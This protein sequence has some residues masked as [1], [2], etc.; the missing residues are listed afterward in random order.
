MR[1]VLLGP[2]GAGKG[3]QARRL[4]ETY[5]LAHIASGDIFLRNI[6]EE[7]ELGKL[8]KPHYE[9][10]RLVPDELTLGMI[11]AAIRAAEDGFVLDGFPRNMVQA[12]IL[13]KE[14]ESA[15]RP[16]QAALAFALDGE[17]AVKRI[18]GRRTCENDEKH[19]FNVYFSPPRDRNRCD[20]C[21][22]ALLQRPDQTEEA[23]RR[24]FEVYREQTAPLLAFYSER[25]LLREVDASGSEDEVAERV[26]GALADLAEERA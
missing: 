6:R 21:G 23:V 22:G 10:G 26:R 19:V 18:A 1:I 25:G 24:R 11:V 12:E 14:L 16:L 3:T 7:T 5:G 20:V 8:A 13:E 17:T 2:P 9:A 15:G 4:S